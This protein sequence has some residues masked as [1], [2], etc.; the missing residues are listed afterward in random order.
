MQV[1]DSIS[2]SARGQALL[3]RCLPAPNPAT[4]LGGSG[5][6]AHLDVYMCLYSHV[7]WVVL[8]VG[9]CAR[10]ALLRARRSSKAVG[11]G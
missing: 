6:C 1:W 3:L 9:C 8:G 11:P 10:R 4:P 7:S 2:A 5:P